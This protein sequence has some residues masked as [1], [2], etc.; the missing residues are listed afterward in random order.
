MAKKEGPKSRADKEV[1]IYSLATT[2]NE[3]IVFLEELEGERLLPIWIGL[4]EGQAIAIRFSGIVL[5]RPLTHDLLL[6]SYKSLGW[7]VDKIVVKR[8]EA[9]EKTKGGIV[10]PDAAKEKPKEGIVV[11]LGAGKLLESGERADLC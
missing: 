1:R 7:A 11:A 9:E 2:A 6:A 3:C 10:L 8:V 4:A 5:P